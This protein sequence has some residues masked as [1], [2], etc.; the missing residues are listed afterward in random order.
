MIFA[1][2]VR[3]AQEILTLLPEQ[4]SALVIGDTHHIERDRIIN[5]FKN[6]QI[7][8]LVNVSGINHWL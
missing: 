2:T 4:E 6:K 1:A 3:H 7:K 5:A 8:Y